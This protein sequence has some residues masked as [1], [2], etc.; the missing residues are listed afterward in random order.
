MRRVERAVLE[1]KCWFKLAL[2]L[3]FS[4]QVEA[5]VVQVEYCQRLAL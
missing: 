5:A 1:V 4:K 3:W 2:V